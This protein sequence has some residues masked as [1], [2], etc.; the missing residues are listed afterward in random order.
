MIR[1]DAYTATTKAAKPHDLVGL[2]FDLTGTSGTTKAGRGF[3]TF[4]E[5]IAVRDDSGS[6]V[7]SVSWGGAQG[8]RVMFEVKG[9]HTPG[10]VEA[11]RGAY[12]HRVTRVDACAD[13]DVPGAFDALLKPCIEVKRDHKL[14]GEKSGD[15]DDF[16]EFGRTLYLGA[17]TSAVKARMYEKGKQPE[18]LHLSRADWCRLEIQVRPAKQAKESFA[19]LTPSEVWGASKWSR[20][21]AAKVLQEHIDPHPAGSTYR[22]TD[23]QRAMNY[24]CKQYG[25]HL[26]GLAADLGGWE[27]L[28]LTLGEIIK[29]QSRGRG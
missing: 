24:M 8:D 3:H 15:W 13:F 17:P 18:Y 6:E 4:A 5:R 14:R 23:R 21:L 16:P 26:V 19:S 10:A 12:E 29:E 7:G 28:G 25:N 9:E 22:Q 27:C 20:D 2:L 11:F 1:F